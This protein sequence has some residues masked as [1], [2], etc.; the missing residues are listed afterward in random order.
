MKITGS[1]GV[2][3]IPLGVVIVQSEGVSTPRHRAGWRGSRVLMGGGS[4]GTEEVWEGGSRLRDE[5]E[6]HGKVHT[7]N[8]ELLNWFVYSFNITMC[9]S[10]KFQDFRVESIRVPFFITPTPN[11]LPSPKETIHSLSWIFSHPFLLM[12]LVTTKVG[13]IYDFVIFVFT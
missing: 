4:W 12:F 7:P 9:S 10:P 8:P 11:P 6:F 3:Y 1:G 13:C 5:P 2:L